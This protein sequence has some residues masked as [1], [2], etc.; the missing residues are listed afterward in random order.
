[1]VYQKTG[2][3]ETKKE[4]SQGDI[5]VWG[6]DGRLQYYGLF[7]FLYSS[8]VT[9]GYLQTEPFGKL[10]HLTDGIWDGTKCNE[11]TSVGHDQNIREMSKD[12]TRVEAC[13]QKS[14]RT[15]LLSLLGPPLPAK[16]GALSDLPSA[17]GSQRLGQWK[18]IGASTII[19]SIRAVL[20]THTRK[21]S[22]LSK[23]F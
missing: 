7:T 23:L 11:Q 14:S 16:L 20:E 21:F 10:K 2:V 18:E 8:F 6:G 9:N 1:M 5:R 17:P 19:I 4:K 12:Q 3:L 22:S 15:L 13:L